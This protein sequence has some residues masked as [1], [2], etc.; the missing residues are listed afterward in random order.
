M[1]IGIKGRERLKVGVGVEELFVVNIAS[2]NFKRAGY[3]DV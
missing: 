1:G 2:L 3:C